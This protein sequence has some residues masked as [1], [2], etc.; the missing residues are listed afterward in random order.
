MNPDDPDGWLD[1]AEDKETTDNERDDHEGAPV[2]DYVD[3]D[4]VSDQD[5]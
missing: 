5:A 4:E 2:V 3:L 1:E